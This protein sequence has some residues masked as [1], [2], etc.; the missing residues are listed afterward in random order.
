M[1]GEHDLAEFDLNSGDV[2][3]FEDRKLWVEDSA[4][5]NTW[6]GDANLDLEFNSCDMVQVFAA[7]KYEKPGE[8]ATWEEGDWNGEPG[9]RQQ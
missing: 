7:G 3:D 2:V 8:T 9:V 6:I 4:F 5:K 1:P